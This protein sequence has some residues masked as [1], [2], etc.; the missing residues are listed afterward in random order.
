LE[1]ERLV[2]AARDLYSEQLA[3]TL[4]Q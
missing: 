1:G 4:Q 2:T 3:P